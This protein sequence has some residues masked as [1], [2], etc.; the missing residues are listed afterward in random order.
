MKAFKDLKIL[1][2]G[3]ILLDKYI[4]GTV[5]RISPEAPI[6]ILDK[7]HT[8]YRLG[9]AGNVSTNTAALGVY[10]FQIGRVGPDKEGK[11]IHTELDKHK[12]NSMGVLC[13][14][15]IPTTLKTRFVCQHTQLLRVDEEDRKSIEHTELAYSIEEYLDT[16]I[17]KYDAII[18]S[19]YNKGVIYPG[20]I[21]KILQLCKKHGIISIVDTHNPNLDIFKGYTCITPN[22]HEL[23]KVIKTKLTRITDIGDA[24]YALRKQLNL[25]YLLVTLSD[26]GML[27]VTHDK[28]EHIPISQ[29]NVLDVT[30]CGDT[31]IAVF[32]VML[33]SGYSALD[34]ARWANKAAGVVCGKMGTA[35]IT[36]EELFTAD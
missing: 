5:T 32:T 22:K 25:E 23:E 24:A 19:D 9:G 26:Q 30:G 8:W 18:I 14:V 34:S 20:L 27:L 33:A 15:T 16:E 2:I 31:A 17:Q 3:D 4:E 35:T 11:I 29:T 13:D 7:T 10:T 1:V 36:S 28:T 21:S 12:I 6:L